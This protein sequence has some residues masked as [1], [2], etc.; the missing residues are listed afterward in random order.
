LVQRYELFKNANL[1]KAAR[2]E[3]SL[4]KG[5]RHWLED[6]GF[7]EIIVPHIVNATGSCEVIDT[8]FELPYF[9]RTAFLTQTG[10]LYLESVVPFF[11]G[12]VWTFGSSFR[13]EPKADNRHLTEFSLL[14]LEFEGNFDSMLTVIEDVFMAMV[15]QCWRDLSIC[16]D[17]YPKIPF[18]RMGYGDAIR[19]LGLNWGMDTTS[20]DEQKLVSMN[21]NQPMFITHFPKELKYFNMRVNDMDSRIV[22]SADFILPF[23]GE[24][25]G[26]AEREY[27]YIK[28]R[29]RLL[30]SGM[31]IQYVAN[32]GDRT[33][34]DWYLNAYHKYNYQLHSG[35]GMGINRVTKYILKLDDIRDTTLFPVNSEQIY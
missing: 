10:Q 30:D 5:A 28:L 9:K 31:F 15:K 19:E 34:F 1:Q 18:K 25:A 4:L 17:P 3:A 23:G 27:S 32:N 22:N 11:G 33:A 26:A 21:G 14:E 6:N 13:A 8:L 24:S 20:V 16:P 2:I 35:F 12:K 7:T 29:K